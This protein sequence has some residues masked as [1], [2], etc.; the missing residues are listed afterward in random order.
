VEIN[1]RKGGAPVYSQQ[2][3]S[4]G[5]WR[6]TCPKAWKIKQITYT[7]SLD[8]L[9]RKTKKRISRIAIRKRNKTT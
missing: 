3:T 9:G 5:M 2:L 4:H 6:F 7:C 1:S 8:G